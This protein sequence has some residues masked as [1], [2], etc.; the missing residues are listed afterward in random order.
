M[1]M[2]LVETDPACPLCLFKYL[3][4]RNGS[5]SGLQAM[6]VSR[7]TLFD[8]AMD[9]VIVIITVRKVTFLIILGQVRLTLK[10]VKFIYD[11]CF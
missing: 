10:R 1:Y 5:I 6:A 3:S 9:D 4:G 2:S 8:A 7:L 11:L